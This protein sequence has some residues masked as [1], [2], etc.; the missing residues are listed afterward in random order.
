MKQPT[1]A[2]ECSEEQ[3]QEVFEDAP[4][5]RSTRKRKSESEPTPSVPTCKGKRPRPLGIREKDKTREAEMERT[6]DMGKKN[7]P[8]TPHGNL[9]GTLTG[10]RAG[11]SPGNSKQKTPSTASQR[12]DPQIPK[13]PEMMMFMGGI[14]SLMR[15]E[16]QKTEDKIGGKLGGLEDRMAGLEER[17][18]DMDSRIE[19]RVEEAI[20]NR[21]GQR[22]RL[23]NVSADMN[24]AELPSARDKRYWKARRSLRLWPIV[25]NGED[26]KTAVLTFLTGKLR[27][28]EDLIADAE[29]SHIARVPAGLIKGPIKHEVVVEFPAV[30]LRD[31]VRKS[32]FNLAGDRNSGIRLEIPHHLMKNFKAL[33]AASYKLK[34]KFKDLR[35]NIK[36]DDESCDL[37][38]EFR[39]RPNDQWKRIR[40]EQAKEMQRAEGEA[41]ELS[42]SDVTSLLADEDEVEEA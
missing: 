31:I 3:E 15:E 5:R 30:D 37:S 19:E 21:L 17:V 33:E 29:D 1:E 13:G 27:L 12:E 39:I 34:Q 23:Q 36:F 4:L 20:S 28:G 38:L 16:L 18:E 6:P 8:R 26:M 40:P 11:P 42:A 14:R 22:Q 10:S 25:G 35:Q 32:A 9:P 2:D 7:N 41:K 24:F